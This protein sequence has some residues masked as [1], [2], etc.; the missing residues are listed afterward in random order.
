MS[1][2]LSKVTGQQDWF[3]KILAKIPGFKGYIERGDRRM[4]DKLLR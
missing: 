2:I 4:S 3:K 1:D